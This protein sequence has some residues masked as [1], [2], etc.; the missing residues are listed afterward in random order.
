MKVLRAYQKHAATNGLRPLPLSSPPHR[1]KRPECTVCIYRQYI[2]LESSASSPAR[3]GIPK[4]AAI[5]PFYEILV[6]S[7]SAS[8]R[9]FRFGI[10]AN[11]KVV[12]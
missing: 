3:G 6:F 4:L 12:F 11:S 7:S 10:A 1:L 2:T 8:S 9:D 5:L